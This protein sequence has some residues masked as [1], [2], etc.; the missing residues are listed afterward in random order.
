MVEVTHSASGQEIVGRRTRLALIDHPE[1]MIDSFA[2]V[3]ERK[4]PA[5]VMEQLPPG[6]L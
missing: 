2:I 3:E 4:Q 5:A 6:L 1:L